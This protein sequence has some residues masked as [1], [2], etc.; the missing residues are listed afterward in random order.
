MASSSAYSF[1]IAWGAM[2][3]DSVPETAE[4]SQGDG[5]TATAAVSRAAAVAG[6]RSIGQSLTI[7]NERSPGA[8]WE[9]AWAEVPA[10]TFKLRGANY[11]SDRVKAPSDVA[12]FE[13]IMGD[14]V[15]S[16]GPIRHFA[17][18]VHVPDYSAELPYLKRHC[19]PNAASPVPAVIVFNCQIPLQT[20]T[21]FSSNKVPP[22]VNA[23]FYM[24][25]RKQ[26]A[27]ELATLEE[28]LSSSVSSSSS[29]S[30][31][32]YSSAAAAA[33]AAA[34]SGRGESL[35]GNSRRVSGGVRLLH[36][37]CRDAASDDG[38]RGQLKAV[39]SARNLGDIGA[40]S[41]IKT[42]NGKPVLMAKSAVIG[43]RPGFAQL[44]RTD[45]YLEVGL[46]AAAEFS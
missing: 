24:R 34:V 17:R 20:T 38:L 43:A 40:P 1:G 4:P 37:W 28:G 46:D 10:S 26:A 6:K 27:E 15:V 41:V 18:R 32:S 11:L 12:L 21:I 44:Y 30:S 42:W 35:G 22:T 14:C 9:N 45:T 31:S 5:T 29:L 3:W 16:E 25:L 39:A 33:A 2:P 7:A 13:T 23:V 36:R 8:D 19:G